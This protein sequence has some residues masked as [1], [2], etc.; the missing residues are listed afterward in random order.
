MGKTLETQ[1]FS[2]SNKN[3]F[4]TAIIPQV[5]ILRLL[6][7]FD[8]LSLLYLKRNAFDVSPRRSY[9]VIIE[10]FAAEDTL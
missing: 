9:N 8:F 1:V 5:S 7:C 3:V 4:L 2:K 6:S 10:T